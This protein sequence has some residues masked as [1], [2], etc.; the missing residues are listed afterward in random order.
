MGTLLSRRD[1][2]EREHSNEEEREQCA[3]AL[4]TP[5]VELG[6]NHEV[7]ASKASRAPRAPAQPS[8]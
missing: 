7:S 3:L 4:G 5:D 6:L 8:A 1:T 2:G